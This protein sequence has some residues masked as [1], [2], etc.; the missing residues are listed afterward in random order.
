MKD[1]KVI[2]KREAFMR[3]FKKYY[4]LRPDEVIIDAFICELEEAGLNG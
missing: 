4:A 1:I 3:V 2:R